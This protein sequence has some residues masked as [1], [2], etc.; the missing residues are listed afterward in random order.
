[1]SP[2]LSSDGKSMAF[3]TRNGAGYQIASMDLA[4]RQV[5]I[6]SSN[7]SKDESPSF[8]PNGKMVLYASESRGRGVLSAVSPDGQSRFQLSI[9]AANVREP[10]W[11]PLPR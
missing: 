6:L 7:S 5:T 1:M 3:V 4:S 2:R 8:A 10:A 11:G 9:P